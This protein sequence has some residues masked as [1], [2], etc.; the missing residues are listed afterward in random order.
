MAENIELSCVWDH[1]IIKIL[2]HDIHSKMGNMIKEWV[3]FNKLE[4][5]KSLLEYTD[6]DFTP[7]GK[8]C[9][10]NE[11]GAMKH[12]TACEYGLGFKSWLS[13]F[14]LLC[15]IRSLR[16]SVADGLPTSDWQGLF[17][18]GVSRVRIPVNLAITRGQTGGPER[19][20]GDPMFGAPTI[21][22]ERSGRVTKTEETWVITLVT[23]GGGGGGGGVTGFRP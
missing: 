15:R 19:G 9:Y 11:N 1:T 3:V 7:T 21:T 13:P 18:W 5:F 2:N 6:D 22:L 14:H 20:G 4:D 23:R 12:G 16:I 8:L 17:R 10:I